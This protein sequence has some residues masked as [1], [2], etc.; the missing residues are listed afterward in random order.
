M[1]RYFHKNK[2]RDT[3]SILSADLF[4]DCEK[5]LILPDEFIVYRLAAVDEDVLAGR[6]WGVADR[7][8]SVFPACV[9]RMG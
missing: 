7:K 6:V 8:G 4:A 5:G 1:R 3:L 2:D 9:A